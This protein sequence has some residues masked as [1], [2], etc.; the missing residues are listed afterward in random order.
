MRITPIVALLAL[1]TT[2]GSAQSIHPGEVER[3][4]LALA[5]LHDARSCITDQDPLR[6]GLDALLTDTQGRAARTIRSDYEK[7][8]LAGRLHA[9]V[10]GDVVVDPDDAACHSILSRGARGLLRL[11]IP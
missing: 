7:G 9:H 2:A 10:V 3:W 6:L 8:L 11:H 1:T 5:P 4:Y